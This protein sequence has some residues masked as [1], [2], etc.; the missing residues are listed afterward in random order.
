MSSQDL[1]SWAAA[2]SSDPETSQLAAE[3][4]KPS[5][6]RLRRM[7]LQSLVELGQSTAN[8]AAWHATGDHTL[9]ESIRK[10]A[11]ELVKSGEIEIVGKRQCKV[12]GVAANV[13][14]VT[15]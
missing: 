7:F 15:E 13:Y 9:R 5:L 3:H 8:E 1:F 4:I 2:R 6:T 10:R 11:A 14:R 12:T